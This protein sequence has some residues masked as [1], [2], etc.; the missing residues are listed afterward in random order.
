MRNVP[1]RM[2]WAASDQSAIRG[3]AAV[4]SSLG[5]ASGSTSAIYAHRQL[6]ASQATPDGVVITST[7]ERQA[8][9]VAVL[10]V[11]QPSDWA[12]FHEEMNDK[13]SVEIECWRDGHLYFNGHQLTGALDRLAAQLDEA[14][15]LR[16]GESWQMWIETGTGLPGSRAG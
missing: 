10:G 1:F 2:R 14:V 8:A 13:N 6:L 5:G 7:P 11:L 15:T 12:T 9:I 4:E 16:A 3:P